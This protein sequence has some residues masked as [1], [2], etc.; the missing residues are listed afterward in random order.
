MG[1][2]VIENPF[3]LLRS[4]CLSALEKAL[5]SLG[6]ERPSTGVEIEFSIPPKAELGDLITSLCLDLAKNLGMRPDELAEE[7]AARARET[8]RGG[9]LS[10]I[11]ARGG[12]LSFWADLGKLAGLAVSS[13]RA[14]D[15]R[16]GLLK[17]ERPLRIVVISVSTSPVR[18]L[19]IGHARSA[20]LGDA[21]ARLLRARGHVVKTYFYIEDVGRQV[22]VLAYGYDRL[23]RPEPEGK[24]DRFLGFVYAATSCILAIRELKASLRAAEE[25]GDDR[26]VRELKGALDSWAFSA[27]ELRSR[28][29]ELFEKLLS[30]IERDEDPEAS[31]SEIARA[32]EER[33][34]WAVRLVRG[35]CEMCLQGF[36]QT[37][38]RLG[39]SLDIWDWESD[40]LWSGLVSSILARLDV[41]S[42]VKRRAGALELDADAVIRALG[43]RGELPI[44]EGFGI[45]PITLMR[46]DGTTSYE[47][48]AAAHVL[49]RL[50]NADLVVSIVGADRGPA[51][52]YTKLILFALGEQ[53]KAKSLLHVAQGP[54]RIPGARAWARRGR[55]ILLDGLLDE[56]LARAYDYV[57]ERSPGLGE[58]EKRA[59][60]DAIGTGAIKFALISTCPDEEIAFTWEKALNFEADSAPYLQYTYAK[61]C[62]VLR[63][64]GGGPEE[65]DFSLL[66]HELERELVLSIARFPGVVAEAADGMRP[67][68]LARF[69]IHIADTFNSFYAGLPVIRARPRG[70]A[71]ARLALV[72]AVRVVLRNAL[73]LMGIGAPERM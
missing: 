39:I 18:P 1:L 40:V 51:Q 43:L 12:Y 27:F 41:S 20:A 63:K 62:E 3:A 46:P 5:A 14:L 17:V 35:L 10:D 31:I 57:S 38:S 24:P 73:G 45:R 69:A 64:A 52:L 2:N 50:E 70:L 49:M 23:G 15:E 59:L 58:A 22:A 34:E 71:N 28:R 25:A 8:S 13:A 32:Y 65:P 53:E 16:Y 9:L 60:A 67:D 37:L 44:P 21:L 55:P 4:E 47:I 48:R 66:S 36:E 56:A 72:D 30:A 61:A 6:L 19:H 68:V 11:R 26:A 33:E 29:P 54:V 42:F 7:V